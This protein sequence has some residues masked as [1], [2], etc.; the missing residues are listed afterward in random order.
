[1]QKLSEDQRKKAQRLFF[2]FMTFNV[3]SFQF[4]SGNIITLYAL[5][6]GAGTT[7]IGLIFSFISMAQVLP[8]LGRPIVTRWGS[9]RTMGICWFLRYL[10][11]T[12]AIIAPLFSKHFGSDLVLL[13][14]IIGLLGFNL[15]RGIGLTGQNHLIGAITTDVDRGIFLSRFQIVIHIVSVATGLFIAAV[16]DF[17]TPLYIYSIILSA[18]VLSGFVA[19]YLIFKLP[20]PPLLNSKKTTK[21]MSNILQSFKRSGIRKFILLLITAFSLTAMIQPFLIVFFKQILNQGDNA[22]ALLLVFGSV[23]AIIMALLTGFV[24]DRLGAKPLLI[25]SSCLLLLTIFPLIFFP[26]LNNHSSLIFG[27]INFLFISMAINGVLS[28]SNIYFFS[29]INENERLDMSIVYFLFTGIAATLGSILGGALLTSLESLTNLETAFRIYFIFM[30]IISVFLILVT[31]KLDQLG[32]YAIKDV[33]A[34]FVSF[35]DLRTLGLLNKLTSLKDPI[36]EQTA[37]Y[38]L[39]KNRSGLSR[40]ELLNRLHSPRFAVR[41]EALNSLRDLKRHSHID[42]AII[43]EIRNHPYTTAYL[44]ADI[45]GLKGIAEAIPVLTTALE[46]KDYFLS[47]KSMVSLARLGAKESVTRIEEIL[48]QTKNARVIIHAATA[49]EILKMP[50]SV[51]ILLSKLE[52]KFQP[53]I[54]DEI[55]LS[56]AGILSIGNFFYRAYTRFLEKGNMGI[57]ELG[58]LITKKDLNSSNTTMLNKLLDS[59]LTSYTDFKVLAEELLT[60]KIIQLG[61]ANISIIIHSALNNEPLLRLV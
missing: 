29:I 28:T 61:D 22:I 36:E 52:K 56:I 45:A 5:R 54:R 27:A 34:V 15:A 53:Y 26:E 59:L 35:R 23:G 33:L 31:R 39:G 24:V 41:R 55:I 14:I 6:L 13:L 7:I 16:L 43:S 50:T 58:E 30:G 2:L 3:V 17:K 25:I 57:A 20:E 4:L 48:I 12:P 9:V 1:M 18:G 49:L 10:L 21:F 51:P 8:L 47:S 37:I 11:I 46:S 60:T 42:Q 40:Q 32:S 38:Q 19:T 44:A